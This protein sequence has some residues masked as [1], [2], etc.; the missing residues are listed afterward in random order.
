MGQKKDKIRRKVVHFVKGITGLKIE[1]AV[2]FGSRVR[3][4]F[5]AQSDLDLILVSPDFHGQAFTDRMNLIY[6][7]YHLW[8]E[9]YP[10]EVLCY[11]PEEFKR[12]SQQIG[13]V[14]DAVKSGIVIDLM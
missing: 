7:Q 1:K 14:R 2:I 6:K 3:G 10:L 13:M 4:D 12:K 11:T 5:I 8:K 9:S